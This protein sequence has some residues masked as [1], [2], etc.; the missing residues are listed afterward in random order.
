MIKFIKEVQTQMKLEKESFAMIFCRLIRAEDIPVEDINEL[1]MMNQ[2][3]KRQMIKELLLSPRLLQKQRHSSG[4]ARQAIGY[5]HEVNH[6]NVGLVLY[7]LFCGKR[8]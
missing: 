3:K 6:C 2:R 8:W 1:Q 5:S 7:P 4:N